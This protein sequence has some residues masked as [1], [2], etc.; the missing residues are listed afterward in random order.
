MQCQICKGR[1]GNAIKHSKVS[2]WQRKNAQPFDSDGRSKH[3]E[4]VSF[5]YQLLREKYGSGAWWAAYNG[6]LESEEWR[7]KRE[8]VFRRDKRLCTAQREW[9]TKHATEVHHLTYTNV[10]MSH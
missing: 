8:Q 4:E 9:C 1:V 5:Q 10:G 6:Y 3:R 7:Q 2:H